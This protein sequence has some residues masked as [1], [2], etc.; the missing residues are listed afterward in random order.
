M[1]HARQEEGAGPGSDVMPAA[2]RAARFCFVLLIVAL[3]WS[4]APMTI[5]AVVCSALTVPIW[6]KESSREPFRT[7]V[8]LPMV[9]WAAAL[10]LSALFAIDLGAS[11]SRLG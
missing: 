2:H 11:V 6:A 5:A 7:P 4:I 8:T 1:V 3:P 9:G 10:V